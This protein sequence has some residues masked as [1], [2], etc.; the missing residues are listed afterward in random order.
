MPY[1]APVEEPWL[2]TPV[3]P[4]PLALPRVLFDDAFINNHGFGLMHYGCQA[5]S[6]SEAETYSGK[7]AI[8]VEWDAARDKCNFIGFGLSW[9]QWHPFDIGPILPHAAIEFYLKME[10]GQEKNLPITLALEDYTRNRATLPLKPEYAAGGR[11][12]GQWQKVRCPLAAFQGNWDST[13]MKLLFFDLKGAGKV[14]IDEI[15]LV[16]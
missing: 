12:T 4:D 3:L 16:E 6:L 14:Y 1:E 9:H 11:F 8:E 2:G 15:R 10:K 7:Q 13:N 5:I